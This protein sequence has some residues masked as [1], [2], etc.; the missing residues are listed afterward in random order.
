MKQNRLFGI[1]YILLSKKMIPAKELANYFEVSIRT[2][3]RDVEILSSLG[4]PVYMN[5]GKN[6]GISLLENYKL[7]KALL[8]DE[9][10]KNI[11]FS[12]Q[13]MNELNMDVTNLFEK[14]SHI[15][16][17]NEENWFDVD[18]GT[19]GDSTSHK[20]NFEQLKK[21]IL[22]KQVIAFTYFNSYG[23]KTQKRVEPLQL[24]FKHNSW[25][26]YG[27]DCEKQ[28]YRI[29]KIMRMKEISV[30]EDTFERVLPKEKNLYHQ[31]EK[32][33]SLK[34]EV[35]KDLSYRVYDEFPDTNITV[36]ENG[37]FIVETTLPENDWLYGYIL[38]FGEHVKVL[39]PDDI[40]EKIIDK[41][42][43]SIQNYS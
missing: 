31:Q 19:W 13:G 27:Y 34:L 37:N 8:T 18:F 26:L 20:E 21:A 2:I 38:S 43:K 12:L 9:E 35:R 28:D 25:Y 10:Q 39:A 32:G 40:K 41:L 33:I 3:Y 42:N 11:L 14:L 5:K 36:L 22:C 17:K 4:I 1:I 15:F 7:D 6:G 23:T 24:C 16:E 29:Y 30:T